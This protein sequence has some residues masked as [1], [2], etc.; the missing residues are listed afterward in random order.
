MASSSYQIVPSGEVG[1]APV[2]PPGLWSRRDPRG[3]LERLQALF[4]TYV[5]TLKA[6]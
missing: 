4:I 1:F 5:G 6:F 2:E 3:L